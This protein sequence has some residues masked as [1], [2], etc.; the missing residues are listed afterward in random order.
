MNRLLLLLLLAP[1][2]LASA[3]HAQTDAALR[4]ELLGRFA[5]DQDVRLRLIAA[6]IEHPDSLLLAEMAATD[7]DNTARVVALVDARGWL[8]PALVGADG[9]NA[10]F[11][12]VQHAVPDVQQRMLPLVEAAYHAGDLAGQSYA[13][14]L[15]RVRVDSGGLQVYGTQILPVDRWTDG[16]P[17][18]APTDDAAGLD[19]R[20]ATV[21][22]PPLADYLAMIRQLYTPAAAP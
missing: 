16:A 5:A 19:A 12:I 9:A 7:A 15:D 10:A 8:T 14:L 22:L 21:G 2:A 4:T 20:R 11:M 17:A 18:V 1:A 3:P 13:L 6:G